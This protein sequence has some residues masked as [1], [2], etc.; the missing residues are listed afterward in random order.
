MFN[1][2]LKLYM[3]YTI[4]PQYKFLGSFIHALPSDFLSMGEEI[5]SGRNVLRRYVIEGVPLVVKSFRPPHLINRLAYAYIRKSKARRSYEYAHLLLERGIP[6]PAPIAYVEEYHLGIRN[7]FYVSSECPYTRNMR[8]FWFTPEIGDRTFILEAFAYF[9]ASMHEAG[10]LHRDYSAGNILFSVI[11]G[12]PMFMVVDINRMRFGSVSEE[13]G[14]KNMERLWLPDETYRI[15]AR[16]YAS[17][18]GFNEEH[19][20]ERVRYYKDI[21]MNRK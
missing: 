3:K 7:S 6:T 11:K 15:I 13:E 18:R 17:A 5:Y 20:V 2:S 4:S 21:V 1:T 19:A 10:V 14:Y 9:T 12:D 16:A 8:E